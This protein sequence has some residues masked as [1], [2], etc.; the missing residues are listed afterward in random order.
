VLG[1]VLLHIVR[2]MELRREQQLP[3]PISDPEPP[4]SVGPRT[5]ILAAR[6]KA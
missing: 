2:D 3:E 1:P 4:E 5:P 6:R